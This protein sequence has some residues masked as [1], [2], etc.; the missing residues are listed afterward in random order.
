MNRS[1]KLLIVGGLLL[2]IWGMAY[3]LYYALFAEHQ[4]LDQMGAALAR[5]FTSA[6]ERKLPEAHAALD[7]YAQ[8]QFAYIRHVDVHSHWIGLAMI[9]IVLG[10]VFDR[11]AFRER[12]RYYLAVGLLA[13]AVIFPL[14]VILQTVNRGIVPQSIA[15]LGVALVSVTLAAVAY[16][17]ARGGARR[18]DSS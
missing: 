17:F 14:G 6:A 16:G 18:G 3:G 10:V 8:A 1:R 11:V 7:A 4:A 5:G 2:A 15:I 12:D 9:L 13:G